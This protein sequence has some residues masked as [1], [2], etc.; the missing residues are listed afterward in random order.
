MTSTIPEIEPVELA[1]LLSESK[2]ASS[3][4]SFELVDVREVE[5]H[6]LVRIEPSTLI[7]LMEIPTKIDE[8]RAMSEGGARRIVLY[9]RSGQRSAMAAQF[10]A[11][12]G[13]V[14]LWNLRGGILAY[15]REV[16]PRL[17]QY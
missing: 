13:L 5:E 8:L 2:K 12:E 10:L 6:E 7:P 17:P 9:C 1:A 3:V 4:S 15:S 11:G 16:D 14:N